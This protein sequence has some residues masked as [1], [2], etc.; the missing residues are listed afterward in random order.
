MQQEINF[1]EKK[2]CQVDSQAFCVVCVGLV[3]RMQQPA[4][5][6]PR[7]IK[8]K[9]LTISNTVVSFQLPAETDY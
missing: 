9:L 3:Q 5:S 2:Q 6:W 4:A 8:L 7:V 1:E